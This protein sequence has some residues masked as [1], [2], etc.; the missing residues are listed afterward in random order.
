MP[1]L[2]KRVVDQLQPKPA[3]DLFAW[4]SELK[5]FGIRVKP[6]GVASF[7][8]QYRN[9]HSQTR[10]MV[11]GRV[12]TL[13]PEEARGVA[14]ERLAAVAEGIDPSAQRHLAR[15][16]LTVAELCDWY[17]SSATSG[18]I[19]GKGGR[20]IK[21]STLAM[22]RSRIDAHVKPLLGAHIVHSLSLHDIEKM[23]ADIA[24]GRTAKNRNWGRG[25]SVAGGHGVASRTAS[26]LRT[27]LSHANRKRLIAN[28]PAAG[29]RRLADKR[30]DR[31]LDRDEIKAL[32]AALL[33][34]E[35][36]C[37]NRSSLA[38]VRFMLLTGFRRMEV[39]AL[40]SSWIDKDGRYVRFPDTKSGAQTRV[41]GSSAFKV[42]SPLLAQSDGWTFPA[43]RGNGHLV[44]FPKVLDRLCVQAQL[45]SVTPHTLR[46]TFASVAAELGFTEMTVAG[47]LGHRAR[48]ITQRYVHLDIALRVAADQT[49]SHIAGLLANDPMARNVVELE[50]RRA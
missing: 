8:V 19:L 41:I 43:S 35:A 30:R 39:L 20:P 23:Q 25:G 48:G 49:S 2:T 16:A 47:L 29:F 36:T 46:H 27:M 45:S 22:D 9:A 42:I 3:G 38:A 24:A 6:S 4:D 50:Q 32:G 33:E 11:I 14:R 44:G 26:M 10:R 31:W 1:K 34:A 7:F 5:G 12:G 28:N 15:D 21:A 13:T 40:R 37:K 18:T 17:L